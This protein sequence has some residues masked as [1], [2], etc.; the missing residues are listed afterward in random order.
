MQFRSIAFPENK[1]LSFGW[2]DGK[3]SPPA[4]KKYKLFP[5]SDKLVEFNQNANLLVK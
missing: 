5:A 2:A 1:H 4:S 3:C